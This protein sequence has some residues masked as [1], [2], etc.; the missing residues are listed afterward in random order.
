M[1][2]SSGEPPNGW[3]AKTE[4]LEEGLPIWGDAIFRQYCAVND[5]SGAAV[6]HA[7]YQIASRH[8][9]A[10]HHSDATKQ[11]TPAQ[12]LYVH[13]AYALTQA[14]EKDINAAST[15]GLK[16]RILSVGIDGWACCTEMILPWILRAPEFTLIIRENQ[17]AYGLKEENF[18]RYLGTF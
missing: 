10:P 3:T 12:R 15:T 11:S 2:R 16:P 14:I 6:L 17:M 13:R 7:G 8:I 9:P 5:F 18:T 1:A 4:S